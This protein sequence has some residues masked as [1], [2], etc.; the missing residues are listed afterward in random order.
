MGRLPIFVHK[1]LLLALLQNANQ[2]G[3]MVAAPYLYC[4]LTLPIFPYIVLYLLQAVAD[5]AVTIVLSNSINVYDKMLSDHDESITHT[6]V[7]TM[8]CNVI[9]N[10][11]TVMN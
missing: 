11:S 10:S 8:V 9:R 4:Y 3:G 5:R 1:S 6:A 2:I 7:R